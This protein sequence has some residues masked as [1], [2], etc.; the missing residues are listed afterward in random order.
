[1]AK[2]NTNPVE[3]QFDMLTRD[4]PPG[5][6]SVFEELRSIVRSTV[7]EAT[8]KVNMG[9]RS[10][11]FSHPDVGYFCGLFPVPDRVDIAFE[12]GVLLADPD[13]FFD[14]L[15]KQVGFARIKSRRGIRKASFKRLL[16]AAVSLPASRAVRLEL[17][18]SGA[19]AE[20]F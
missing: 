15:G 20:E 2:S 19:R 14:D 5:I 16:K 11:N 9:W 10:L 17:V 13:G 4:L 7:P 8:E 18:R 1:L 6:L 12:F 3:A